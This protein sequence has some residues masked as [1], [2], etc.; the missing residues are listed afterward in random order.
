MLARENFEGP[1]VWNNGARDWRNRRDTWNYGLRVAPVALGLP[2][3]RLSRWKT[4][5]AFC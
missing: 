2:V 3:A 5:R 1:H 4:F